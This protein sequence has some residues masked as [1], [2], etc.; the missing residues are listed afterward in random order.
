MQ[1]KAPL[2]PQAGA[3]AVAGN[4]L[5]EMRGRSSKMEA[6]MEKCIVGLGGLVQESRTKDESWSEVANTD[7][8]AWEK[9]Q[10]NGWVERMK[11]KIWQWEGKPAL[12]V[13]PNIDMGWDHC[14]SISPRSSFRQFVILSSLDR[15]VQLIAFDV[16]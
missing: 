3:G 12:Y 14:V 4:G 13:T 5:P 16:R 10:E 6:G 11:R 8:V 1:Q 2:V 7:E 9:I 15:D